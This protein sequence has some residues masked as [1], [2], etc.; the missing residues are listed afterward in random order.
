M[1]P[2]YK[3][4]IQKMEAQAIFLNPLTISHCANGSYPFA[5]KD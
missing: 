5:K 2:F 3:N 4:F 1:L